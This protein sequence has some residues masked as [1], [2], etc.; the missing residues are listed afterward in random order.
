[1]KRRRKKIKIVQEIQKRKVNPVPVVVIQARRIVAL[2]GPVGL[3]HP[4][5]Q[6]V[7]HHHQDRVH[8]PALHLAQVVVQIVQDRNTKIVVVLKVLL[9]RTK[10]KKRNVVKKVTVKKMMEKI[11]IVRKKKMKNVNNLHQLKNQSHDQDPGNLITNKI[12]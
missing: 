3:D 1:M 4:V 8:L 11:K 5:V 2:I 12:F 6:V 9:L 10:K 7:D